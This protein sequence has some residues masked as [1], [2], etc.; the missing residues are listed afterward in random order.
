MAWPSR[1]TNAWSRCHCRGIASSA[2]NASSALRPA[3]EPIDDDLC[4]PRLKHACT[5]VVIICQTS[6]WVRDIYNGAPTVALP[7]WPRRILWLKASEVSTLLGRGVAVSSDRLV[8]ATD[9]VYAGSVYVQCGV[10]KDD[11]RVARSGLNQAWR[12]PFRWLLMG[13]IVPQ[14]IHCWTDLSSPLSP[15]VSANLITFIDL[16]TS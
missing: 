4:N 15:F 5:F 6:A 16:F 14:Y 11:A 7:R 9:K 1:P 3:R 13:L 2:S 12:R 10:A 8:H